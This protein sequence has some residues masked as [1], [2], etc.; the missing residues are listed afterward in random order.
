MPI[1]LHSLKRFSTF[2]EVVEKKQV[3]YFGW[4]TKNNFNKTSYGSPH[5]YKQR[6]E[7]KLLK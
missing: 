2:A 3:T 5:D 4:Q 1:N 7:M 6:K